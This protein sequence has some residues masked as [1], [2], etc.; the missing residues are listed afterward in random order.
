MKNAEDYR[1][2]LKSILELKIAELTKEGP[3]RENKYTYGEYLEGLNEG[4]LAGMEEA[5]R[6]V[7]AS[8]FLV[9]L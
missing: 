4:Y 2:T 1:V 7:E 9:D 3:Y 8:Q 5:L 6:V